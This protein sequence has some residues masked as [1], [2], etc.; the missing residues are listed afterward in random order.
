MTGL[1]QR[2]KHHHNCQKD[3]QLD[4]S[5]MRSRRFNEVGASI[6]EKVSASGGVVECVCRSFVRGNGEREEG[7]LINLIFTILG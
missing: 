3:Q 6:Q 5:K 7:V 2:N 1:D 4:A